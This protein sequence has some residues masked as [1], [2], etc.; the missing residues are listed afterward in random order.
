MVRLRLRH[1]GSPKKPSFRIVATDGRSPRDGKFIEVLGYYDPR[2]Q[3][4]K[5]D[6]AR[7]DFW[8]KNGAQPSETVTDIVER[9]RTGKG[10]KPVPKPK[11]PVVNASPT[12]V[13]KAAA[14][15][16]AAEAAAPVAEAAPAAPAAAATN[17]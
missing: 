5:V 16:P 4:E 7:V 9:A 14:P 13:E 17:A 12:K 15:A 10:F 3:D 2:H 11:R 1:T 8:I 6:L